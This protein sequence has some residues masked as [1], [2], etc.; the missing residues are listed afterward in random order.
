MQEIY[1]Q[2]FAQK[3]LKQEWTH[4]SKQFSKQIYKLAALVFLKLS[5]N[6]FNTRLCWYFKREKAREKQTYTDNWEDY[7]KL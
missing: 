7:S 4:F 2:F 5:L 6:L 1:L 3:R